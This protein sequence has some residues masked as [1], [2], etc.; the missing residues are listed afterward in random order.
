MTLGQLRKRIDRVD[1]KILRL[2]NERADA[3]R[4]IGDLKR[5][6]GLPIFD[7]K[8]ETAVLR[9]MTRSNSG[10]LPASAVRAIFQVILRHNRRLQSREKG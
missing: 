2:L 7:G 4:R 1:R 3:A 6:K 10:T 9:R 5:R 8:R